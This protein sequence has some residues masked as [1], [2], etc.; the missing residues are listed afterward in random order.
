MRRMEALLVYVDEN[1]IRFLQGTSSCR[2]KE[3]DHSIRF[4]VVPESSLHVMK[5]VTK[6]LQGCLLCTCLFMCVVVA[7][8]AQLAQF[9]RATLGGLLTAMFVRHGG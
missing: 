7:C 2:S 3:F 9:H 5:P 8:S 1:P 4:M 6:K